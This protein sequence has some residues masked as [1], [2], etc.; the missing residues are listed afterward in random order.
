MNKI[1]IK[2]QKIYLEGNKRWGK[3]EEGDVSTGDGM[4]RS[5]GDSED[6]RNVMQRGVH[7]QHKRDLH[8]K[9]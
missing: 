7:T 9:R 2:K 1:K 3:Q 4:A 8:Y 6:E 5:E